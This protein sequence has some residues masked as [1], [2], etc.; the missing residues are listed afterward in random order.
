MCWWPLKAHPQWPSAARLIKARVPGQAAGGG[1]VDVLVAASDAP[2]A[3]VQ[4]LDASLVFARP[5][6]A[7]L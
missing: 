1:P 7:A 5:S 2:T 3:R 6:L 4:R